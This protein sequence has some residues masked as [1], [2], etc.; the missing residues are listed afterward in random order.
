[1]A[2]SP[3]PCLWLR[4]G[5]LIAIVQHMILAQG[6]DT[7]KVTKVKDHASDADVELGRVRAE[8]RIGTSE[9]D[10]GADLERRHQPEEVLDIRRSPSILVC[11]SCVGSWLLFS[12]SR[13]VMIGVAVRLLILLSGIREVAVSSA[14]LI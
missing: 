13:L 8:G 4:D 9:A 2:A 3:S 6:P 7:V 10:T 14:K 1:M 11:F 12:R 5:D